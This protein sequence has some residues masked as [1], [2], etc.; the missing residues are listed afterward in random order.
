[1]MV[2]SKK[3]HT[4]DGEVVGDIIIEFDK[5]R[6]T[7]Q[8]FNMIMMFSDIIKDSGEIGSFELDIFNVTINK[9][10][11]IQNKLI[12]ITDNWYTDKLLETK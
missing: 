12:G 6:L 2:L 8:S 11:E 3:I 7:Q 10:E 4:F 9:M 1:M 5:Q